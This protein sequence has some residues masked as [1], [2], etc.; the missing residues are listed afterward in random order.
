MSSAAAT[1]RVTRSACGALGELRGVLVKRGLAGRCTEV[2][3]F[4]IDFRLELRLLLVNHHTAN[5][6]FSHVHSPPLMP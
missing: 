2:V 5:W 6:I 4:A 1:T 3:G